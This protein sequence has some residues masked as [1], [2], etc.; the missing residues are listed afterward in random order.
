MWKMLVALPLV[1]ALVA[2]DA[3]ACGDK[4]LVIGRGVR[5]QRVK[6]AV[7]RAAILMYLDPESELPAATKEQGLQSNLRLAGHR[8]QSV[9]DRRE[10]AESLRTGSYDI[11]LA[12][13]ADLPSLEPELAA[14]PGRPTLLPILYNPTVEELEAAKRQYQCVLKSPSKK[15][16]YLAVIEDA[17]A[18]RK[19]AKRADNRR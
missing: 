8:L 12:G 16:H 14:S 10:L 2:G 6:G 9:G 3:L 13:I 5:S 17:L 18:L 1:T 19:A 11:V 4:F 7:H 15:Q